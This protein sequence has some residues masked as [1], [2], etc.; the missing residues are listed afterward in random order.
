MDYSMQLLQEL[1]HKPAPFLLYSRSSGGISSPTTYAISAQ[2]QSINKQILML[3]AHVTAGV[4]VS[5]ALE[6]GKH[7][8]FT[9]Q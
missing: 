7:V 5:S 2:S 1:L 9:S 3:F 4:R 6:M 8:S